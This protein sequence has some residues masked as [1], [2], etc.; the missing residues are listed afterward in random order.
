MEISEIVGFRPLDGILGAALEIID[1][2]GDEV[3]LIGEDLRVSSSDAI[4]AAPIM[5]GKQNAGVGLDTGAIL[6]G[7]VDQYDDVTRTGSGRPFLGREH[8]G[9]IGE[10]E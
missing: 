5:E 8:D 6:M 7:E 1:A 3:E 4:G 2:Q 9:G 10:W